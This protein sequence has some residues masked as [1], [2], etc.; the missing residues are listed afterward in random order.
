MDLIQQKCCQRQSATSEFQIVGTPTPS[1]GGYDPSTGIWT[2]GDM[3]DGQT[4]TLDITATVLAICSY[5]PRFK[6]TAEADSIGYPSATPPIS[7]TTDPNPG[8]NTNSAFVTP[9]QSDLAVYKVVS[10]PEPNVGDTIEFAIGATNYGP[11]DATGVVVTDTIPAGL[12]Y[13]GPSPLIS[14]NP[15]DGICCLRFQLENTDLVYWVPR[16]WLYNGSANYYF[17]L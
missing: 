4:A 5:R 10:D 8:N 15:S 1:I 2:I 9:L 13:V 14:P 7:P 17:C 12:T 16:C 6:N 3:S 11:A